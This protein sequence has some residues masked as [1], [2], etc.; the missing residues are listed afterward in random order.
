MP[1]YSDLVKERRN[2]LVPLGKL[3]SSYH[4]MVQKLVVFL[5]LSPSHLINLVHG[6][7]LR[8]HSLT[9]RVQHRKEMTRTDFFCLAW[10]SS[11]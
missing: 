2:Q 3:L 6:Q 7:Y 5:L 1:C 4:N 8:F 9:R 10:G 11:L